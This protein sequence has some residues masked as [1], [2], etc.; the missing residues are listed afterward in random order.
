MELC[1]IVDESGNRTGRVAPRGSAL[2]L[3]EFFPV[4]HVWI[5]D[6]FGNYLIQQ[7]AFDRLSDPGVWAITAGYILAGEDS[8][9]G[10]IREVEEELGIQLSPSHLKRFDRHALENRLEDIWLA[11]IPR[12]SMGTPTSG[13]EVANWKWVSKVELEQM[14]G[15]NDFFRYSYFDDI[16]SVME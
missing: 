1:D 12:S 16:L 9:S 3:G 10:A 7:R 8:L 13:P 5:R 4:V 14:A 11:D 2:P 15:R 6:E